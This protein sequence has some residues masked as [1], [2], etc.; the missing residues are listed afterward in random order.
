M[1]FL[2]FLTKQLVSQS[3]YESGTIVS[4][5]YVLSALILAGTHPWKLRP[6]VPSHVK[7]EVPLSVS[8]NRPQ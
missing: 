7:N 6:F 1:T 5:I 3:T 8:L 2:C 4:C